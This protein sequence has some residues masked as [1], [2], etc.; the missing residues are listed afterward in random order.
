VDASSQHEHADKLIRDQREV[1]PDIYAS[2]A[3]GVGLLIFYCDECVF[4]VARIL[5]FG[6]DAD[7]VAFFNRHDVFSYL[8]SVSEPK[9]RQGAQG[10]A[11]CAGEQGI[12]QSQGDIV[13]GQPTHEFTRSHA[14]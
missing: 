5:P 13:H 1:R 12:A 8:P 11:K 14:A 2:D 7:N 10:K 9:R 4:V 3:H 6:L